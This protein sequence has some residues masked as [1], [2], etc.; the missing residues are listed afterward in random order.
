MA[1]EH[2]VLTDPILGISKPSVYSAIQAK[3]AAL[4][5]DGD[6]CSRQA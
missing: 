4:G 2:L 1:R 3:L 6:A 5:A